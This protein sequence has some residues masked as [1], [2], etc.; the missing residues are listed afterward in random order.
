MGHRRS[1]E[2][3]TSHVTR[4]DEQF[5]C[6]LQLV[7]P[8]TRLPCVGTLQPTGR[9]L[10]VRTAPL[11]TARLDQSPPLP[12]YQFP[13]EQAELET[14]RSGAKK[15]KA[16]EGWMNREGG[17]L[18]GNSGGGGPPPVKPEEKEPNRVEE[19]S[20]RGTESLVRETKP[21]INRMSKDPEKLG[22]SSSLPPREQKLVAAIGPPP[23]A[24]VAP[25]PRVLQVFH[26]FLKISNSNLSLGPPSNHGAHPTP[27]V[28]PNR[29]PIAPTTH[30]T[31]HY[32]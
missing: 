26:V 32:S 15:A 13:P 1:G 9:A 21:P 18:V 14:H 31:A 11:H 6:P 8:D 23:V 10:A 24:Q 22:S 29:Y 30:Q 12:E 28:D 17:G 27:A 5:S 3:S 16:K 2:G 7:Q 25:I 4:W 19:M 20:K